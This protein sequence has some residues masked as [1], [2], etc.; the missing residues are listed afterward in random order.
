MVDWKF[1]LSSGEHQKVLLFFFC[2]TFW[3]K[4]HRVIVMWFFLGLKK[5]CMET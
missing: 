5:V 3:L 1:K 2:G 4:S